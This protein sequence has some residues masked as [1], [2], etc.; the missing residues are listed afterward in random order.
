MWEAA[1]GWGC[2]TLLGPAY[3]L[4]PGEMGGDTGSVCLEVHF[5]LRCKM[6]PWSIH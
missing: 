5:R 4:E 1:L 2:M 3:G 6:P